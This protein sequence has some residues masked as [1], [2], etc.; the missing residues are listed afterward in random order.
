MSDEKL[1]GA[2]AGTEESIYG[3]RWGEQT[4]FA[5]LDIDKNSK[6]HCELELK[7]LQAKLAAVELNGTLYRS[8]ESGGWHL[9]LFFDDWANTTEVNETLGYW[10]RAQGYEI[11]GGILEVFPSGMGLRLPLQPGFAWLNHQSGLI[12]TREEFN[13]DEA[14][15][16]FLS[17]LEQNK[18]SWTDAKSRIRSQLDQIDRARRG[19]ALAHQKAIDTEG[20]EQLFNCRLIPEKY[21][22]GRNYWLTGLTA[23]AQRHN[24]VLAVEH[25]LW[26]G[27]KSAGLPA[28]PGD[29]NDESRYR[30][31]LAWLE[32]GHNGFC[33]HINRG[34]WQKVKAHIRRACL[35]RRPSGVRRV[36]T[37]YP[38]TENSID[39][40]VAR[41]KA[42]GR[43]WSM[44][45][46]KKGNDGREKE[47]REKIRQALD[48]LI[49]QGRKVTCR[50]LMRISGCSYHTVKRHIDIWGISP[51]LSL[52]RAAG[53]RSP[54]FSLDPSFCSSSL[55]DPNFEQ[56][57]KE[58]F[59]EKPLNAEIR[60]NDRSLCLLSCADRLV[61][62][63]RDCDGK[64]STRDLASPSR[65][66]P[67]TGSKHSLSG[68]SG[69]TCGLNGFLPS[70]AVP[71]Q[72]PPHLNPRGIFLEGLG[73]VMLQDGRSED[74]S[75]PVCYTD[76]T[77][78]GIKDMLGATSREGAP[79]PFGTGDEDKKTAL[80]TT[81]FKLL[82]TGSCGFTTCFSDEFSLIEN[83]SN[84]GREAALVAPSA[85]PVCF[86]SR[87]YVSGITN[88]QA[89]GAQI[90]SAGN[91]IMGAPLPVASTTCYRAAE[92]SLS[93]GVYSLPVGLPDVQPCEF[94]ED[95]ESAC[96]PTYETSE[97]SCPM[98]IL[99]TRE[100]TTS[101]APQGYRLQPSAYVDVRGPP[102]E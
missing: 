42:T 51:V 44:E 53:D 82:A 63:A 39:V 14:I 102:C 12:R 64:E 23:K 20:F 24:A 91:G 79:P 15:A 88:R 89:E 18:R 25:Y 75:L 8:S 21:E 13:R 57:F 16:S 50:Q 47:A 41:S 100:R 6:Y 72:G 17:D 56:D 76:A 48:V 27:D 78:S 58:D 3:L 94:L 34:R 4:R 84:Q 49:A 32:Q 26:H 101:N 10:L 54:F 95:L 40:L 69:G 38:F 33:N 43:T 52:P 61:A 71:A 35:W 2:V 83:R 11:R 81:N 92:L 30:M 93:G 85:C 74:S 97:P 86:F 77:V 87:E 99:T 65:T 68:L 73:L 7:D 37:P 45:D 36:E 66:E 62:T 29:A 60:A 1:L 55:G 46:L 19:D 28:L 80:D 9:Y 5:V 98:P 67:S 59:E 31:I 22:D 90:K 96:V 70:L